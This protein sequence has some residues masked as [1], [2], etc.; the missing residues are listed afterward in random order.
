MRI[1]LKARLF[2]NQIRLIV[3]RFPHISRQ[4]INQSMSQL[5][6]NGFSVVLV[7]EATL[8]MRTAVLST[9]SETRST[10]DSLAAVVVSSDGLLLVETSAD[11]VE[12]IDGTEL[13]TSGAIGSPDLVEDSVV[14]VVDVGSST[15]TSGK[16]RAGCFSFNSGLLSLGL[17]VVLE[18]VSTAVGAMVVSELVSFRGT[19]MSRLVMKTMFSPTCRLMMVLRKNFLPSISTMSSMV[20]VWFFTGFMAV[21]FRSGPSPSAREPPDEAASLSRSSPVCGGISCP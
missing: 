20:S 19:K 9:A 14:V 6:G 12:L 17:E 3:A 4:P 2:V 5:Y 11:C 21:S 15:G 1:L 13:E 7:D 16:G 18:V 10:Q 8:T